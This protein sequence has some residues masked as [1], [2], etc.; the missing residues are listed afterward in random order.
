M[1]VGELVVLDSSNQEFRYQ[2]PELPNYDGANS[3]A[4]LHSFYSAA[5]NSKA[6]KNQLAKDNNKGDHRQRE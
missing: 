2:L 4:T 1:Q 3:T 6:I 5:T